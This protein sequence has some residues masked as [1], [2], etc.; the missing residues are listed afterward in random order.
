MFRQR[1]GKPLRHVQRIRTRNPH[2]SDTSTA[3]R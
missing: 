1:T 3:S 2:N